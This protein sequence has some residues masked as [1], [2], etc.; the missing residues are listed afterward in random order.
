MEK[1]NSLVTGGVLSSLLKFAVPVLLANVLHTVYSATDMWVVG[2]FATTADVSAVSMASQIM[3]TVNMLVFGLTTGASVLLGQYCGGKNERGM[4]D[5]VG[6]SVLFFTICALVLMVPLLIFNGQLVSLM[7]TPAEAVTPARQYLYICSGGILFIIGYNV[8]SSIMRGL[9]DSKTPLLFVGVSTVINIV[10]DI[11]LV[12]YAGMGAAGAAIATVGAQGGSILFSLAYLKRRGLGFP[13]SA[14]DIALKK[15]VIKPMLK[16]GTPLSLQELLVSLSFMFI[17]YTVNKMGLVES[18]AVGVVEKVISFLSMPS[19]AM[20]SA[21][22]TM[23]AHNI[24]AR[25]FVRARKSLLAGIGVSVA[26]AIVANV[27][28]FFWGAGLVGIFT[29]DRE[30]MLA[31]AQYIKSYGIDIIMIAII[32]NFNGFM[33]GANHSTFSMVHS[34]FA[35]LCVRVPSVYLISHM[36]NATLFHLGFAAPISSMVS[37]ILCAVYFIWITRHESEDKMVI[38]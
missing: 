36:A 31:G 4:R 7:K 10:A 27:L 6:T 5:V 33:S 37:I 8:I 29:G 38:K 2:R 34:L 3:I 25:E 16:V 13:F 24:G 20:S 32:F 22:A 19:F 15:S 1:E 23:C 28:T 18:A 30:V 12:K 14:R 17:T 9:G 35:T 21:V 11:I 26:T